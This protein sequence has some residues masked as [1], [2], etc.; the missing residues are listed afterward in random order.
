MYA[1]LKVPNIS[2]SAQYGKDFHLFWAAAAELLPSPK[3]KKHLDARLTQLPKSSQQS[4]LDNVSY[5]QI[6]PNANHI[7]LVYKYYWSL[8]IGHH[9]FMYLERIEIFEW[10]K[11]KR[12]KIA[13]HISW[14]LLEEEKNGSILCD[15]M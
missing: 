3:G 13:I 5:C 8:K 12:T 2:A 1:F 10:Y 9:F 15:M 14:H 7:I 4:L 11:R 6:I